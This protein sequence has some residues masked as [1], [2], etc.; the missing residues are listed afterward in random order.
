LQTRKA[1]FF[2]SIC[3]SLHHNPRSLVS[4]SWLTWVR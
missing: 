2:S 3:G 1:P 4:S